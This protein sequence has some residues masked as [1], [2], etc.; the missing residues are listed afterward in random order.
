MFEDVGNVASLIG[1]RCFV[2]YLGYCICAILLIAV[3]LTFFLNTT[4]IFVILFDGRQI[5][6]VGISDVLIL[7]TYLS[8]LVR[9]M[10]VPIFMKG[11]F[12]FDR[13][14]TSDTGG[15][16]IYTSFSCQWKPPMCSLSGWI[17]SITEMK[18]NGVKNTLMVFLRCSTL[19][20]RQLE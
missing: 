9:A 4:Q 20:R 19:C 1:V 16:N 18:L 3:V 13:T 14:D 11:N 15:D 12:K 10:L 8:P 7:A 5:Q 17:A 2:H 6:A